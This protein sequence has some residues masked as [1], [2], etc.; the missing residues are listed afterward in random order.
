MENII[1]VTEQFVKQSFRGE[2]TG[3]DWFHM[4]RVRK[5][6]IYIWKQEQKG[7]RFIIEMAALLHDISDEKLNESKEAGQQK[8]SSFLNQL[9]L[10]SH[11]KRHIMEIIDSIS[12]KGGNKSLLSSIEAQIV[13]DADRLDAIGAIGI[14]RAFAYGGKKGQPIYDPTIAV[15]DKMT[16]EEY[17]MEKSST[18]HHF[19]E[20]LFKLKNLLHTTTAKEIAERRDAFM[21]LFLEEF[22]K[23]WNGIY[24]NNFD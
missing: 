19:Y 18:V 9:P 2:S 5:N 11:T 16:M 13:Q 8:L 3:H 17:R 15:R 4:E 23:D 14:S 21:K 7:D 24:E 12:Y 6:A 10:E 1:E 22:Y 20:K